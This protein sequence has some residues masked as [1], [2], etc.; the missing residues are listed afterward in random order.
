MIVNISSGWGRSVAPQVAAYC[1]TKW[2]VEG[3]T[4]A[5]AEELPPGMAAVPLNPGIINTD[6]LQTCWGDGANSYPD[7]AAWATRAVPMLLKLGAKDNGR[8]LSVSG[9]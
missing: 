7:A 8:P 1:G 2:A 6:M 3:L 5:L 4:R 9:S